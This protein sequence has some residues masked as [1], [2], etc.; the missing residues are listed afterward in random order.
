MG[1]ITL[2]SKIRTLDLNLEFPEL[3]GHMK[4]GGSHS[5]EQRRGAGAGEL[6]SPRRTTYC[7]A[8]AK[9]FAISVSIT[10]QS[11]TVITAL[12]GL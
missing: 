3:Q 8:L 5:G 10:E 9:M 7:S 11:G 12:G 6:G 4:L 2:I 1:F